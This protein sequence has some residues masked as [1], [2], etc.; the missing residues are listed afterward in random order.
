MPDHALFL[1]LVESWRLL[2]LVFANPV[3]RKPYHQ[4]EI[5][6]RYIRKAGSQ[7]RSAPISVG[8]RSGIATGPGWT[9]PGRLS[10]SKRS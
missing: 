10:P 6:K 9:K 4:E 2:I 8:I 5:Q 7:P 3:T 1:A